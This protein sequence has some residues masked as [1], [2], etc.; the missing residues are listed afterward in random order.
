MTTTKNA[1]HDTRRRPKSQKRRG[2][3]TA[4][5][6]PVRLGVRACLERDPTDEVITVV[7]ARAKELFDELVDTLH[8][9]DDPIGVAC[10]SL[11]SVDA[12]RR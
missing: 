4:C 8:K 11:I 10:S 12:L 1:L 5:G 2:L 9:E 6:R 7:T 3:G